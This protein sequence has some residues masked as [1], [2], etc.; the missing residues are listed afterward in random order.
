MYRLST[1][2]L[3]F[4]GSLGQITLNGTC[5]FTNLSAERNLNVPRLSGHWYQIRRIKNLQESGTCSTMNINATVINNAPPKITISN[6]EVSDKKMHYRNG[7]ITLNNGYIGKFSINV[8]DIVYDSMILATNYTDYAVLY[9]CNNINNS[10]KNVW[11]WVLSRNSTLTANQKDLIQSV[12]NRNAELK[13][14]TWVTP[15]HSKKACDPNA[16]VSYRI[17]PVLILI[18]VLIVCKDVFSGK[19]L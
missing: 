11:A 8:S 5:D 10:T 13:N 15:E 3:F 12:I 18:S 1:L 6:K 14:A 17:S 7:T 4:T 9:S 19:E 16:S 2:L